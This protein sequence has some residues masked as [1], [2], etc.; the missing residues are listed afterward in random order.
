M[1]F[2]FANGLSITTKRREIDH[3]IADDEHE[4]C[5]FAVWDTGRHSDGHPAKLLARTGHAHLNLIGGVDCGVAACGRGDG[6]VCGDRVPDIRAGAS[7]A[8]HRRTAETCRCD[9]SC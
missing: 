3:Q 9:G 7:S 5:G 8:P 6:A 2:R 1:N 4:F